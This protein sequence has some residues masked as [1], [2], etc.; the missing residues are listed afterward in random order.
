MLIRDEKPDDHSTVHRLTEAA[1]GRAAEAQLV[2]RLRREAKPLV[3]LVAENHG[4]VVGHIMFTPVVIT[5]RPA[6]RAMGLAPMAVAPEL[7][8]GGIG[9]ALVHAGV[10]RCKELGAELVV[11]LGHP[12]FYPRF[13]FEPASRI[14]LKSEYGV[15][16]SVFMALPL[17]A[18]GELEFDG[19]VRYHVAF[20]DL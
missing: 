10:A 20:S 11:V 3:S 19:T 18:D 2:D 8:R 14:G 7:Q 1:F 12:E 5:E 6:A 17:R 15:P 16:D 4:N 9:T 13:G